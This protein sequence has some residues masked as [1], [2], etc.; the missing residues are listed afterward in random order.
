MTRDEEEF[1]GEAALTCPQEEFDQLVDT[2]NANLR[3]LIRHN[4]LVE[5]RALAAGRPTLAGYYDNLLEAAQHAAFLDLEGYGLYFALN[6]TDFYYAPWVDRHNEMGPGK[7]LRDGGIIRRTLMLID[8]DPVRPAGVCSTD[9]EK[10][11]ARHTATRVLNYLHVEGWPDPA[12]A[13]SGNGVHLYYRVDLPVD[14]QGL[15]HRL[16]QFLDATFSCT[17]ARIDPTVGN[18]ARVCRIPGTKNRKGVDSP[19]RPFRQAALLSTPD[20][21]EMVPQELIEK[22]AGH[23]AVSAPAI[24]PTTALALVNPAPTQLTPAASSPRSDL[25]QRARAKLNTLPIAI[26]GR[27]GSKVCYRAACLLVIDFGLTVAEAFPILQEWS[28]RCQPPWTDKELLHK[29]NDAANRALAA[30]KTVGNSAPSSK[31]SLS[32]AE[33][34]MEIVAARCELWRAADDSEPYV[35]ISMPNDDGGGETQPQAGWHKENFRVNSS[36]FEYALR[37]IDFEAHGKVVASQALKEAIDTTAAKARFQGKAFNVRVRVARVGEQV[38]LDLGND[39]WE[40]VSVDVAGWQVV[41]DPPCKFRRPAGMHALPTPTRG[42]DVSLLR[43]LLNLE[44]ENDLILVVGWLVTSLRGKPPY[45]LLA[46]YGEQG[47]AKSTFSRMVRNFIDPNMAQVKALSRNEHDLIIAGNNSWV[48]AL[49]NVSR[50]SESL[51]DSLCR[52][53]TGVGFSTRK[54]F[55]DAE[56][57]IFNVCRPIQLNSI[58]EVITRADLLDRAIVIELPVIPKTER[59][60]DE[61]MADHYQSVQALILGLLL[62]GVACAL[63][64]YRDLK[65]PS[66]NR[67]ADFQRWAA[68]AMPAFGWTAEDFLNAYALNIEAAQGVALDSSP[69]VPAIRMLLKASRGRWPRVGEIKGSEALLQELENLPDGPKFKTQ[70]GWPGRHTT[71]GGILSRLAPVMRRAGI[72][73]DVQPRRTSQPKVKPVTIILVEPMTPNVE[74]AAGQRIFC[75]EPPAAAPARPD[76]SA[77]LLPPRNAGLIPMDTLEDLERYLDEIS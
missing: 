27:N 16:L 69:V 48:I 5:I 58:G 7:A 15:V 50:I 43:K 11:T 17:A 44:S 35:T 76:G 72:D 42:G 64:N 68:A 70:P 3:A 45:P 18:L 40:T 23:A 26:E 74:A 32:A 54:L 47:T 55:T 38:Y 36:A 61:E 46:I 22:L 37:Y 51:S 73:V 60:T 2:I 4:S 21:W 19:D 63:R 10:E 53:V 28:E 77:P 75:D 20:S 1:F 52:M 67:M 6:P 25:I 29:L 65:L 30:P 59:R 71:L 33:R 62:D 9:I 14:D 56:E 13:D 49:D 41:G 24:V 12:I 66:M 31:D 34:L 8:V 57:Q 39:R